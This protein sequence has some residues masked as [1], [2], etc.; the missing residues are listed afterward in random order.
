MKSSNIFANSRVH[1][2]APSAARTCLQ[3]NGEGVIF[4]NRESARA[5]RE[6]EAGRA[7]CSE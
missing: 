6:E 7:K 1:V 2:V 3:A 5:E 4:E